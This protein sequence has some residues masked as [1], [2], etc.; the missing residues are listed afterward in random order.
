MN[1]NSNTVVLSNDENFLS[2]H[3]TKLL[4]Y[5]DD[6]K[7]NV[8]LSG[9]RLFKFPIVYRS[10]LANLANALYNWVTGSTGQHEVYEIINLET[11]KFYEIEN[12]S[13][14]YRVYDGE[15]YMID[16]GEVVSYLDDQKT[17]YFKVENAED[18]TILGIDD[19]LI[20][21]HR[22]STQLTTL[23][24]K[25]GE[26]L[27]DFYKDL[28]RPHYFVNLGTD[29]YFGDYRCL[30]KYNKKGSLYAEKY[31]FCRNLK[32]SFKGST[33]TNILNFLCLNEDTCTYWYE[34]R[35]LEVN[36]GNV[37][38]DWEYKNA[39]FEL[40]NGVQPL[41]EFNSVN[42]TPY[43]FRRLMTVSGNNYFFN[44]I[45]DGIITF[46]KYTKPSKTKSARN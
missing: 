22:Y 11:G 15:L 40:G 9:E 12:R 38:C 44:D 33:E 37:L 18:Y 25:S 29:Y 3:C 30:H 41:F 13:A 19:D 6:R 39:V 42:E 27:D 8:W 28:E 46:Y 24:S 43:K 31:D 2:E 4:Y 21:I 23:Y 17:T 34:N 20:A 35:Y 7:F 45:K 5:N 32:Y 26:V 36:T 14:T 10:H 16:N 1:S